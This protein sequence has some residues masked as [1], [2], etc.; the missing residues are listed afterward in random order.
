MATAYTVTGKLD[1]PG[2][3]SRVFWNNERRAVVHLLVKAL[4]L[5][6]GEE[7]ELFRTL[8]IVEISGEHVK[9]YG[10]I[11][12]QA[13]GIEMTRPQDGSSRYFVTISPL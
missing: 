10:M 12:G 6:G 1:Q 4:K 3:G 9:G 8:Q 7:D 2:F 11:G 5:R 13:V